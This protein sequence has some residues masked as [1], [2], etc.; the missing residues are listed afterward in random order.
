MEV[1]FY[2]VAGIA[3]IFGAL[4]LVTDYKGLGVATLGLSL[5][6]LVLGIVYEVCVDG[7]HIESSPTPLDVYRGKTTLEITYRDSV[8]IDSAVVYKW[9]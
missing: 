7:K 6:A 4:M 9:R 1:G 2:I 8:A 5:L 3:F